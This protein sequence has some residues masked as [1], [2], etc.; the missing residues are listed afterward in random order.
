MP[1]GY[2]FR[3]RAWTLLLAALGC[4]AGIALGNWQTHRAE[5]K[6]ALAAELEK[7][8][9][10]VRGIFEPQFTILLDNKLHHGR[11]GYEVI[12]PLKRSQSGIH[13]LVNRGWIAAPSTRDVLP[14]VRT[15]AGEIAVEG[16]ALDRLPQ[17]LQ[18]ERSA[19]GKVRQNLD[20]KSYAE[21]TRLSVAPFVLEQH[22]ALD[23]G[24]VRDWPAP[25]FGIERHYGYAFQWFAL[26][27]TLT[28][29]YAYTQLRNARRKDAPHDSGNE[30]PA[31]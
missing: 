2:S 30:P 12:T 11:P 13:V 5:Q 1:A 17:A 15:P 28:V 24:L 16:L 3:P 21:E 31:A 19:S 18:M 29:F 25:D 9:V 10:V 14:E 6:K 7:K 22:S 27:A 26:A 4:A 8:H 20:I 23:D